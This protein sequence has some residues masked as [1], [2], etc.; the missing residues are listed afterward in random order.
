MLLCIARPIL[1]AEPAAPPPQPAPLCCV[2][3][4]Q[5]T[6]HNEYFKAVH[7]SSKNETF[8]HHPQAMAT[9]VKSFAFL[10]GLGLFVV[11]AVAHDQKK[12]KNV[13]FFRVLRPFSRVLQILSRLKTFFTNLS[14]R[15][16]LVQRHLCAKF[17]VLRPS[18]S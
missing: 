12:L 6:V 18:Q 7:S 13:L 9:I 15:I 16:I 3:L 2:L 1:P 5:S 8:G 10:L 11:S 4:K 14:A 17:D